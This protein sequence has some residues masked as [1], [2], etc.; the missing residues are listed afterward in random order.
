MKKR[1]GKGRRKESSRRLIKE[2]L[3]LDVTFF[4][5]I[6]SINRAHKKSRG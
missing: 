1:K 3:R 2:M 4:F 6:S 5:Y